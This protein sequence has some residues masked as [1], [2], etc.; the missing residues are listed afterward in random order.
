MHPVRFFRQSLK[1]VEASRRS[2]SS[3]KNILFFALLP[4]IFLELL[5]GGKLWFYESDDYYKRIAFYL[6]YV[7][8]LWVL[9][10]LRRMIE[11]RPLPMN[12]KDIIDM[13]T[14]EIFEDARGGKRIRMS[15]LRKWCRSRM[16]RSAEGRDYW[17]VT[18]IMS[19]LNHLLFRNSVH[20]QDSSEKFSRNL[21]HARANG[22][23]IRILSRRVNKETSEISIKDET[24]W[25]GF[26]HIIP[27]SRS[28][29]EKYTTVGGGNAGIEDIYF[30]DEYV[31]KPGEDAFAL[32]LFTVAINPTMVKELDKDP[33]GETDP[34]SIGRAYHDLYLMVVEHICDLFDSN[35]LR[36]NEV[37]VVAQAF[38][39]KVAVV[40][41]DIGFEHVSQART[42]DNEPL[43]RMKVIL[44]R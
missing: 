8:L 31:C 27:I 17:K 6:A 23:T 40:L 38:H 37:W 19:H 29:Y 12:R 42:A 2:S 32:L 33:E 5:F 41:K 30:S 3:W 26:S 21:S 39:P 22:K 43:Y 11:F 13:L 9:F 16:I 15:K 7:T 24:D 10:V 25:V 28:T 18:F 44:K 35:V 1:R 34:Q 4:V 20:S 14:D 36:S